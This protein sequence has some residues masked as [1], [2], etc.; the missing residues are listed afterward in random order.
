MNPAGRLTRRMSG[1][2]AIETASDFFEDELDTSVQSQECLDK[3]N[4]KYHT[5]HNAHHD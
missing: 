3:Q 1:S 5:Q 2:L 4:H